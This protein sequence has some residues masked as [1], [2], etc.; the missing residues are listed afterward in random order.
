MGRGELVKLLSL[1]GNWCEGRQGVCVCV[2]MYWKME[3]GWGEDGI[4]FRWQM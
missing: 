1:L 3:G 4:E 2:C